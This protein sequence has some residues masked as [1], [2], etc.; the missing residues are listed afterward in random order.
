V[1]SLALYNAGLEFTETGLGAGP[2]TYERDTGLSTLA[3]FD[4]TELSNGRSLLEEVF[5]KSFAESCNEFFRRESWDRKIEMIKFFWLMQTFVG[6]RS[7]RHN[8]GPSRLCS[9][10]RAA[11]ITDVDCRELGPKSFYTFGAVAEA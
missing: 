4:G 2:I 8:A 7:N 11:F 1:G 9:D 10:N 6:P 5:K 3:T